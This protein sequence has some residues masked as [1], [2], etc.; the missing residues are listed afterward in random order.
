MHTFYLGV[1]HR[2][3]LNGVFN[4][5]LM[6]N[7]DGTHFIVNMNN[8]KTL[9]FRKNIRIFYTKIMSRGYSMKIIIRIF[10]GRRSIIKAWIL[11]LINPNSNYHI[12]DLDDNTPNIYYRNGSK[13]WIRP[14]S[15]CK[16]F[17]WTKGIWIWSS[18]SS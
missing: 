13:S 6:E 17:C 15:L 2:I 16:I 3:F 9:W 8:R 5:N 11:I 12:H 1:L 10:G 4:E 14:N 18:W 7:I